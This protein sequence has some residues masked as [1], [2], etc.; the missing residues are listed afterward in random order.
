MAGCRAIPTS[1]IGGA[2]LRKSLENDSKPQKVATTRF[3]QTPSLII[4]GLR[5]PQATKKA[6]STANS[7]SRANLI[8]VMPGSFITA[9]VTGFRTRRG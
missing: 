6:F 1:A 3:F 9:E 4:N 7:G 5:G 8:A 2:F